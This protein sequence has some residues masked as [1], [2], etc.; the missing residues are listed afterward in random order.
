MGGE[1]S[2]TSRRNFI[3]TAATGLAAITILP[4]NVVAGLGHTPPSSRLS[5]AAIGVGG[6]GFKNLNAMNGENIVALC[7]VDRSY[8]LKAFRRWPAAVRYTDFRKMLEAEKNIDAVLIAAPDHIH[9][10]AASMAMRL[11]K[12]V[13][14]QSPMGHSVQEIRRMAQLSKSYPIVSQ[15]GNTIASSDISRRVAEIIWNGDLGEIREVDVWSSGPE[16][17]QGFLPDTKKTNVPVT[18]DWDLFLGPA[19]SIPYKDNYT[20]YGWRAFWSFGS[21]TLGSEA[22]QL[23]EPVFRALKLGVASAVDASSSFYDLSVAPVSEKFV[24]EFNRRDNLPK[25]SL[26]PVTITWYDG[27]LMPNL[28]RD[29]PDELSLADFQAGII[30]KGNEGLLFVNVFDEKLFL[31]KNGKI[32]ESEASQSIFRIANSQHGHETDWLRACK[33]QESNRLACSASFESQLALSETILVGNM[34]L[35]LQSLKRKLYWDTLRLKFSNIAN[36]EL[37]TISSPASFSI[38]NAFPVYNKQKQQFNAVQL[39]EQWVNPVYREGWN[40]I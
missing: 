4:S 25:L 7:D 22:P 18:L 38:E 36:D 3:K 21:G 15:V 34:A 35:R 20:P 16:W 19:E 12:H 24:F 23:L 6:V 5:I 33:E 13:F 8:G 2:A 28:P 27:G 26:P 29:I 14:V 17:P 9:A 40:L 1:Q 37:V 32:I 10:L 11:G 39:V 31:V 30:F